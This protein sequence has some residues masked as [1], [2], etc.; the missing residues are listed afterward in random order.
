MAASFPG[1]GQAASPTPEQG[2][3]GIT[4]AEWGVPPWILDGDAP[5]GSIYVSSFLSM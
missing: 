5:A 4:A 1:G 3:A 2:W